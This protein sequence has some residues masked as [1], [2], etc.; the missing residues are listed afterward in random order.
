MRGWR[1][2]LLGLLGLSGLLAHPWAA[3][4]CS[5]AIEA[6]VAPIGLSVVVHGHAVG[7][8]YPDWLAEVSRRTGCRFT[9]PIVP[10]A[11]LA[12][13]FELGQADLLIPASRTSPRDALG[14]FVPLV[15]SRPA[16]LSLRGRELPALQTLGDLLRRHELR[17]AVVRGFDFG[18]TYRLAVETFQRQ[19]RL[20][21]EAEPAGVARA[22]QLGIADVAIMAPTTLIGTLEL[23]DRLRPLARELRVE[24][25]EELPW[26]DSGVYLSR[27]R[28]A[29]ADRA[30]LIRAFRAASPE[31]W[32]LF[33][34][35]HPPDSLGNSI[36]PI[37]R[38]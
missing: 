21:L 38:R 16:L 35:R 29:A 7:G 4:A 33:T 34:Q 5:R 10:R 26:N 17:V 3:A 15:R 11:R 22:L 6:P 28:L 36:Q 24:N 14:D 9:H 32:P 31:V 25:I 18:A 23:D 27:K 30:L 19:G 2:A 37:P 1:A 20:I 12:Q 13:M 8:I